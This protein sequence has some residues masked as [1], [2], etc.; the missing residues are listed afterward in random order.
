MLL[1]SYKKFLIGFFAICAISGTVFA[2]ESVS[3][4]IKNNGQLFVFLEWNLGT[5]STLDN[6]F[7]ETNYHFT[8]S[9]VTARNKSVKFGIHPD[10]S[11]DRQ[12][13]L[14]NFFRV[15]CFFKNN[16]TIFV[17]VDYIKNI[18]TIKSPFDAVSQSYTFLE[19]TLIF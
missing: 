13:I 16:Y 1:D 10:F 3:N 14:Q 18:R 4:K 17:S 8:L 19:N 15:D 7:K 2:K 12:T 9:D 5:Y 11:L 6:Q